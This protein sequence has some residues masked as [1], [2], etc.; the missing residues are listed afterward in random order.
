[1]QAGYAVVF[2]SRTG[3]LQPFLQR[4]PRLQ[5]A[6]DLASCLETGQPSSDPERLQPRYA[7]QVLEAATAASRVDKQL[8]TIHFT[9]VFEYMK[10]LQVI[11]S[12]LR[13]R[14]PSCTVLQTAC[15]PAGVCSWVPLP[16]GKRRALAAWLRDMEGQRGTCATCRALLACKDSRDSGVGIRAAGIQAWAIKSA[17]LIPRARGAQVKGCAS[18]WG[19]IP[20]G[21]PGISNWQGQ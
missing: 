21:I 19:W 5:T 7:K 20:I 10:Y 12:A 1:M 18:L 9:T 8:L 13:V 4:L 11:A 16:W 17:A 14:A 3:S 2:L 15:V 6:S